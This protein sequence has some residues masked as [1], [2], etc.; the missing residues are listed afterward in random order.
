[1]DVRKAEIITKQRQRFRE[2]HVELAL[3]VP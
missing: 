1:V 3:T 2:E